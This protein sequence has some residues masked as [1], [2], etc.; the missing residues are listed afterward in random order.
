MTFTACSSK[1][2][3]RATRCLIV[4]IIDRAALSHPVLTGISREHLR[5]SPSAGARQRWSEPGWRR[6]EVTRSTTLGPAKDD[7]EQFS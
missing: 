3:K 7:S 1:R 6:P 2:R 4:K 5:S